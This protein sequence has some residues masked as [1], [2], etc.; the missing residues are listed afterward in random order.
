MAVLI[1][2][3]PRIRAHFDGFGNGWKR[4]FGD[5]SINV[6][7]TLYSRQLRVGRVPI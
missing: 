7:T 3:D 2:A 5:F 4:E 6:E 1:S